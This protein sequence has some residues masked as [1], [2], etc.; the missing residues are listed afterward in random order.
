MPSDNIPAR[1]TFALIDYSTA[2]VRLGVPEGAESVTLSVEG[3]WGGN[4]HDPLSASL[5]VRVLGGRR[6]PNHTASPEEKASYEAETW[7]LLEEDCAFPLAP[8]ATGIM[9]QVRRPVRGMLLTLRLTEVL[10]GGGD[11][12]RPGD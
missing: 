1:S 4:A 6:Q 11:G 2:G 9:L 8:G 3:T 10:Q 12:S 7:R 5:E